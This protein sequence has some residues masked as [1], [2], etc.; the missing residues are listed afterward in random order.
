MDFIDTNR[1]QIV[2]IIGSVIFFLFVLEMV[3]KQKIKEQYALLWIFFGVI[4][5]IIS[6]WSSLLEKLASVMGIM[7]APA[8]FLLILIM[9]IFLIL[10]QYSVVISSMSEKQKILTQ[11]IA[12]LKNKINNRGNKK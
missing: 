7:Y 2:A 6:I 5:L 3:R 1:M 10:I 8:A 12:L 11:E 4:F 9:S